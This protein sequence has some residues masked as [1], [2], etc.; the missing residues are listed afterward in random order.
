MSQVKTHIKAALCGLYKYSGACRVHEAV[1]RWAGQQFMVVLLFHRVTDI[2]PEDGLTVSTRRFRNVCRLL[3]RN[4]RVV[5]LGEVFRRLRG[6][7][8]MPR[9]TIAITFDDSY[10][11]NLAAARVLA[12]HGLPATFFIPTGLIGTERVFDWDRGLPR[13]PNL[14]WDDV[15]AMARMGFEI[16]SHTITHANLGAVSREQVRTEVLVSKATIEER[17]GQPVRW[18]AYPFGG[19]HH[20]RPECLPLLEEA[21]Y[22]GALSAYG[23]FV[24]P[25]SDPFVLPREAVPY[26]RSLLNLELHLAGCLNWVYALKRRLGRPEPQRGSWPSY[27]RLRAPSPPADLCASTTRS[28]ER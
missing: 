20:V 9:R 23:G 5:P 24:Q 7:E 8:P 14:T 6:G 21:G 25:D 12:E 16:G 22:E 18:F 1:A 11:D 26:F 17:I 13:M 19:K 28:D 4:F 3:Q 10:Q 15:R 2:I 27:E